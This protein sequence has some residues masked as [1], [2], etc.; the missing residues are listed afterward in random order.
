M[1]PELFGLE[2]PEV[3][4]DIHYRYVQAGADI[5]ETNTFGANYYKLQA[6]G[7]ENRVEEINQEAVRIAKRASAGKAL[8]AASV[9]PTGRLLQPMGELTFDDL[10]RIYRQQ[11]MA[12]EKAGADLISIETMTTDLGR[13]AGCIN[14]SPKLYQAA[15]YRSYEL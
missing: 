8:V 14:S 5:I 15:G 12:C 2:H 13:D 3:L 9:G 10:Y 1:C 7:L 11:I 4:A 6:Y